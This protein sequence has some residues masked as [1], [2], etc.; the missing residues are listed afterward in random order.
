MLSF[1]FAKA[2][3]SKN[4]P[5][6]VLCKLMTVMLNDLVPSGKDTL[7]MD[8]GKWI[9]YPR[10]S[11]PKGALSE[12]WDLSLTLLR[13]PLAIDRSKMVL[14]GIWHETLPNKFL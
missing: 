4:M 8:L 10:G 12:L 14:F 3:N 13:Y 5:E 9:A 1:F 6:G 2:E 7:G 11:T